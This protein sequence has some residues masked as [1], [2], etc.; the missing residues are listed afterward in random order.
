M[1]EAIVGSALAG[2]GVSEEAFAEAVEKRVKVGVCLGGHPFTLCQ[3]LTVLLTPH[4]AATLNPS[5]CWT[6]YSLWMTLRC[7]CVCVRVFVRLLA[8]LAFTDPPL[9]TAVCAHDGAQE[10]GAAAPWTARPGAAIRCKSERHR[11]GSWSRSWG[12]FQRGRPCW[13]CSGGWAA[14]VRVG[15]G[16][17]LSFG[18]GTAGCGEQRQG[19]WS[20]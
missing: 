3:V 20:R 15:Q 11:R 18:A 9:Q 5:S 14:H 17:G 10:Q 13:R 12:C 7:V 1:K 6:H 19:P 4:R 2:L 8:A 16:V